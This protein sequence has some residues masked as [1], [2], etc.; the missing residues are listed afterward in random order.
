MDDVV[1]AAVAQQVPHD[2]P[3]E[4]Q[5]LTGAAPPVVPVQ[6]LVRPDCDHADARQ[7]RC[8]LISTAFA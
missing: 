8:V 2:A 5:G 4:A 6:G 7:G 3:A 1:A